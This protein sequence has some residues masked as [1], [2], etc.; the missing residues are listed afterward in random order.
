MIKINWPLSLLGGELICCESCPG[1]FHAEC[2]EIVPPE[3]SFY[4]QDCKHRKHPTSGNIVWVK[5]GCYRWWPAEVCH[6]NGVP[7]NIQ[8]LE[9]SVGEFPVRFFGS[10]DYFWVHKGRVFLFQDGDK[11]SRDYTSNRYLAKVFQRAV[12]E[13]TAAFKN[14]LKT[15]RAR[16]VNH[17]SS[18]PPSYK[19]IKVCN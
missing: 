11:G 9:H 4:C 14:W 12:D 13:A 19:H 18:K 10:H 3:E 5:L 15:K 16:E 2:L 6:P 7:L 8:K 1:A 17:N